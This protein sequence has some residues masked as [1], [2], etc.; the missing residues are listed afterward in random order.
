MLQLFLR[1]LA[2]IA[3][4]SLIFEAP[5]ITASQIGTGTVVSSGGLSS[6]IN[7]N[8]TFIGSSASGTING[9]I[10]TGRILPTLNM[11]ISG[12]GVLSLGNLSSSSS[13]TGTVSIEIG[14][15]ALNGASVTA[16]STNAGMTNSSSGAIVINSLVA[17][18]AADSYKFLSVANVTD[19]T[20]PGFAHTANLNTEVN[21]SV[22]NHTI[23][24]S[25]RPQPLTGVNDFDF[26]VVA[27]PNAQTPAGDYSDKVVIT[28]TGNF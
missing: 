9:V 11:T 15:N 17:D 23:Y 6:P 5:I 13:A 14:T 12:S 26:S 28:V 27:L 18:G 22:T 1:L 7:W 25:N 21:S 16:R 2:L 19:S 24:T 4:L 8:D 10:V 3:L 20:A